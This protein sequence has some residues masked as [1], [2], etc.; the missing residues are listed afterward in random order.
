MLYVSDGADTAA[1]H[2]CGTKYHCGDGGTQEEVLKRKRGRRPAQRLFDAEEV[3]AL[4]GHVQR[5]ERGDRSVELYDKMRFKDGFLLKTVYL[6][7]LVTMGVQP[8]LEELRRFKAGD[9]GDVEGMTMYV[10]VIYGSRADVCATVYHF[11]ACCGCG[12]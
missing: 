8:T 7:A 10:H 3:S 1:L 9:E 12:C 2:Q 11:R 6:N 5:A 4:G